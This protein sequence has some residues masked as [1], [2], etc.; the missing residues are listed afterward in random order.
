M[1]HYHFLA[2]ANTAQGFYSCFDF[3]LP[4]EQQKRMY[5]IKGGPGVGKSTLMKRFAK[6]AEEQG[7]EVEYFHC[8]SDPDSLDGVSLPALGVG[9]MDGTAPHVYDPVIPGARDT[10]VSL[11]DFLDEKALIPHVREIE[12]VQKL[13]SARFARCY[14]YLAASGQ[15]LKAAPLAVENAVKARRLA[16]KWVANM[17]LRGGTGT[18]RRL[19]ASA[20]TPKGQITVTDFA[21][22]ERRITIECPFGAHATGLMQRIT[23]GAVHRGLHVIQLLDPLLP[24]EIAHVIIPAHGLAYCTGAQKS[25]TA[26]EWLDAD[27]LFDLT[28][29]PDHEQSFDRNVCELLWQRATE[30]LTAA[31]RLHDE[32][33]RFYVQNMDFDR[34]QKTADSIIE[35]E[36]SEALRKPRS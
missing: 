29:E 5:Y 27:A 31:K 11:G 17:P 12:A 24:Q 8:S 23:E 14:R 4:K 26:G 28:G 13:I 33:E 18:V 15:A 2:G 3:I 9:M 32:L 36:W 10:L 1:H 7:L 6:A 20:F 19:F 25:E 16:E 34:W 21:P 22:L 30:Q 35:R